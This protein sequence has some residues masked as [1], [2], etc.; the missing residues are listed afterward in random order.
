MTRTLILIALLP[1]HA[2]VAAGPLFETVPVFP[3]APAN[4]PNYR[5]PSILQASNGDLLIVAE[6]RNDGIG[7][8]GNHDIVMKRSRDKG[9]TWGAEQVIFDD[10]DHVCTDITVGLDRGSGKLWLFFL[11]DKKKYAHFTS[12]DSGV[13]WQGPVMIH[14]QVTRP[15]WDKL[16][17]KADEGADPSSAGRG[18][19]WAKGWAQRYGCGPG[20]A[21]VVVQSGVKPGRIIVP[22]RHREDIGGGKLRSFAHAFFSD[23]HGAT[24]K[25]GGNIGLNTSECQLTE[26]ANGDVMVMSRN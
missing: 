25:L 11:R 8:I 13:T 24:W 6:R 18:A 5:I 22:A 3:V 2:V 10:G 26:L 4:R 1:L 19:A 7:D 16:E 20:N 12:T 21:I 9:R 23:D 17:G 14:G 15:E